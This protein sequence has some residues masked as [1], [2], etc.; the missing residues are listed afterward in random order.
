MHVSNCNTLTPEI[1]V[2]GLIQGPTAEVNYIAA[3][4]LSNTY[5]NYI[6]IYLFDEYVFVYIYMIY[7]FKYI[8]RSLIYIHIYIYT[9]F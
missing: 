1:R 9:C 3:Y 5:M 6:Y 4:N 7:I 8:F 2:Y